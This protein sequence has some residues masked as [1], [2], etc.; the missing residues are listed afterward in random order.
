MI[1]RNL[2]LG[3][4]VCLTLAAVA[5]SDD[6]NEKPKPKPTVDMKQDVDMKMPVDMKQPVDMKMPED[7]G[8]DQGTQDMGKDMPSDE[9]EP[10]CE[11]Y[12]SRI[13]TNCTGE[14]AQYG[15]EAECLDFCNNASG[16]EAGTKDDT[17]G[18]TIACR[19]YH[20]GAPAVGDAAT[21]CPHAGNT[22]AN[23][24]GSWCEVYCDQALNNC[25]GGNK[26]YDTAQECAT[27][28]A[29][30]PT[31]GAP[32]DAG[33][34]TVQ[35]RIY[36]SGAP[37]AA[38]P[39]THCPH[40]GPDGAMV[41]VGDIDAFGFRTDPPTAYTQIDRM[42]MPAV[43]TALL[44]SKDNYN[45]ANPE[46]DANGT[47]ANEIVGNLSG[48]HDALIDDIQG[49]GLTPCSTK[50]A[51]LPADVSN[52]VGQRIS[53]GGPTVQSLVIPDTIKINPASGAGF[54]NGRLLTDPVMD[55]T[56]SIILLDMIAHTP[57]ALVGILNPKA[58]DLGQEGA[59][60]TTF[61]YL[62]PAHT[63]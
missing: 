19:I 40:A 2:K 5:C 47:Y 43:S 4:F 24:C 60:L 27:A 15:S 35:C 44:T 6:N 22:G 9:P 61:P 7:M 39:G 11:N 51:A 46:A 14:N 26:L 28:C 41:C 33:F 25:T 3:A 12:C 38:Q 42:G 1:H 32:D 20:S 57:T 29:Q 8:K 45:K 62:H 50:I 30:F 49:A 36:H 59:F 54:P 21:H 10:T 34:N 31:N 18:N 37:A 52:C 58:N 13:M 16:W 17:Q 55:V 56:L 23:V 48:I 53:Q 63:P